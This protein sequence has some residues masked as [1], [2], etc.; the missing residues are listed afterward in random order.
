MSLIVLLVSALPACESAQTRIK[1]SPET[2][3]SYSPQVQGLI[4]TGQVSVGFSTDQARMALGR[5]D[6]VFAETTAAGAREVWVYGVGVSMVG[7]GYGF[8]SDCSYGV[9][10]AMRTAPEV[11]TDAVWV[12]ER[13]RLTFE[14][15][16]LVSIWRRTS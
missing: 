11:G 4:R 14:S 1:H 8:G 12:G 10:G 16:R 13:L 3:A 9:Y 15:N 7:Y 2:F 5:P 6:W